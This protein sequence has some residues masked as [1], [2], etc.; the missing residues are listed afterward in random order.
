VTP[1]DIT[2]L[3][4]NIEQTAAVFHQPDTGRS[5]CFDVQQFR[6]RTAKRHH[7]IDQD[8]VFKSDEVRLL[9]CDTPT[10]PSP[11]GNDWQVR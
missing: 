8:F 7:A 10:E 4:I 5:L 9:A 3:T 1:S 11:N 6:I 2:K